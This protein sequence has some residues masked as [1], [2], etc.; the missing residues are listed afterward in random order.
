MKRT[1]VAR[2]LSQA[3]G[4]GLA[5]RILWRGVAMASLVLVLLLTPSPLVPTAQ[6]QLACGSVLTM[7]PGAR[8]FIDDLHDGVAEVSMGPSRCCNHVGERGW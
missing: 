3:N 1:F 2:T 5:G 7:E 4:S 6:A 8:A